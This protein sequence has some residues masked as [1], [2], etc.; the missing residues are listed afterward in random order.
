[1]AQ[2]TRHMPH[3]HSA[4]P[5]SCQTYLSWEFYRNSKLHYRVTSVYRAINYAQFNELNAENIFQSLN[6]WT[7]SCLKFP[8][9]LNFRLNDGGL[10]MPTSFE[11]FN[12]E[13]VHW[14]YE[15]NQ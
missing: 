4:I 13:K 9:L 11:K 14:H 5:N 7:F 12:H 15:S 2:G 1:M 3:I 6:T 10:A 8:F